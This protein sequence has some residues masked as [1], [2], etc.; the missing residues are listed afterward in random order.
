MVENNRR[1][2]RDGF[3]ISQ[4]GNCAAQQLFGIAG[5]D[6]NENPPTARTLLTWRSGNMH[7]TEIVWILEVLGNETIVGKQKEFIGADPPRE[8]HIDG[9]WLLDGKLYTFDAKS[10]NVRSFEE[11]LTAAGQSKYQVMKEG[12]GFYTPRDKPG[13]DYRPVRHQYE[14]YYMQAQGYMELINSRPEYQTYRIDNMADPPQALVE[15]AVDGGVPIATD[16]FFFIVY[17]KDNS[18]IYIEFVPYDEE[19]IRERLDKL[20]AGYTAVKFALEHDA[21]AEQL[22]AIARDFK[23]VERTANGDLHW[24]CKRCPFVERCWE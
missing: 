6:G 14:S 23:E 15:A 8:G 13:A 18:S 20:A 7:E 3:S 4:L 12:V 11:W 1:R 5:F 24:K 10:A 2:K 9:L 19:V 21:P 16:G 22:A 17:C